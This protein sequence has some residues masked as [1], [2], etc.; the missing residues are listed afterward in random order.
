MVEKLSSLKIAGSAGSVSGRPTGSG[1]VAGGPPSQLAGQRCPIR[2]DRNLPVRSAPTLA[3]RTGVRE[4]P[5]IA[6]STAPAGSRTTGPS[7]VVVRVHA[8]RDAFESARTSPSDDEP[9]V[10]EMPRIVWGESWSRNRGLEEPTC[11]RAT[12]SRGSPWASA[13]RFLASAFVTVGLLERVEAGRGWRVAW[14]PPRWRRA[15]TRTTVYGT[16]RW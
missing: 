4:V 8:G 2:I 9:P 13:W 6:P 12:W 16:N 5:R 7:S 10:Q 14:S 3:Q 1:A 15:T 11:W